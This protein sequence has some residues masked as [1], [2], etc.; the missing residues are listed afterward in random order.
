MRYDLESGE[1]KRVWNHCLPTA[2]IAGS[3]ESARVGDEMPKP[4]WGHPVLMRLRLGQGAFRLAVT[5]AY[6][7]SCAVTKEHSLPVL[8]AAHIRPFSD[9]GPHEITNG[10]LLR[11]DL[12]RLF[13]R[14]YVTVTPDHRLEVSPL[15]K[16]HFDNGHS[17]Y[18]LHGQALALPHRAEH[19]P[20]PDWLQWH[21]ERVFLG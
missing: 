19:Q 10:L 6:G 9:E 11:S 16:E 1:G 18:P 21:N 3:T 17:Y 7:R 8:E 20:R 15:L 12:H 4:R 14:G 5:A 13:D 2:M